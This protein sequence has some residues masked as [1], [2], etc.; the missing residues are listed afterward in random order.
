MAVRDAS[1]PLD[2][3]LASRKVERCSRVV[4][5]PFGRF[6]EDRSERYDTCVELDTRLLEL[7]EALF[8]LRRQVVHT[9]GSRLIR[10]TLRTV[11]GIRGGIGTACCYRSTVIA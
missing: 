7:R 9:K 1:E 3:D 2:A 11:E 6:R 4:M 8:R 5:R 10:A